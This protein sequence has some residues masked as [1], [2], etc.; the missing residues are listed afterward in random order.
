MRDTDRSRYLETLT[1]VLTHSKV[2]FHIKDA[3]A[4]WVA[5][6]D[7]ATR[8]E[9][10]VIQQL[11][12][13]G[14]EFPV[15]MRR[16]LFVSD[17]WFDVLNEGDELS[18]MLGTAEGARLGCLLRW[19]NNIADK[20]PGPV[21]SLL[22]NWWERDSAHAEQLIG[23]FDFVHP[24]PADQAV[25]TLLEDVIRS[26]PDNFFLEA[27]WDRIVRLLPSVCE[28]A[29]AVASDILRGLFA[30]WFK[31]YPGK[32]PFTHSGA[33]T[34]NLELVDLVEKTLGRISGW[35]DSGAS[36]FA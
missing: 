34:I 16:A 11:D 14:E 5:A 29:P 15:L 12:D 9:L 28:V 27:R 13:A 19:L 30:Q 20:R 36:R 22:R 3:V 1:T 25:I 10:K 7:S 33:R 2:R 26:A 4:H 23:W 35:N 24:M 31:C 21:A 8:D 17:S 18:S 6:I 32:H